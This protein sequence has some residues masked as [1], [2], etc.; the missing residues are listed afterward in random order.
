MAKPIFIMKS[1]NDIPSQLM[2]E[3]TEQLARS[4]IAREY[5]TICVRNDKPVD[6]FEV[7]NPDTIEVK[8]WDEIRNRLN[9]YIKE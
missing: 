1:R 7:L 9:E 6:E 8:G 4:P 3:L 5:H 2:Q